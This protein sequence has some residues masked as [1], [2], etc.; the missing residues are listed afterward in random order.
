[1]RVIVARISAGKG[2]DGRI[3]YLEWLARAEPKSFAIL[4]RGMMPSRPTRSMASKMSS[5]RSRLNAFIDPFGRPRFD[6]GGWLS[7]LKR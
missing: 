2:E 3:G 1:L 7:L 5:R 4:L 6:L